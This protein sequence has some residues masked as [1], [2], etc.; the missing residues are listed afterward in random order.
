[1][2]YVNIEKK[3]YSW[4]FPLAGDKWMSCGSA[5][6]GHYTRRTS[7]HCSWAIGID[8]GGCSIVKVPEPVAE[9][10]RGKRIAVA[11]VSRNEGQAANAVYRK[12]R[13]S[14]YEALPV[15]PNT[16]HVEGVKCFPNL[17]SIPGVIDGVVV[18]THPD[19]SVELVRQCSG[20]EV[21][22]VWF[23]RSFGQGSVSDAA[24]HECEAR[25]IQCIVG[26]CPLMYSAPVD[27]GHRCM[28][29]WLGRQ[30]VFS[31]VRNQLTMSDRLRGHC[32]YQAA[33]L[34]SIIRIA[35]LIRAQLESTPW[36]H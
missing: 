18:A 34:A 15:N 32:V 2:R 20:R 1:L 28:R 26:G 27:L 36:T 25:G 7:V 16:S 31:A 10:L 4:I 19:V 13:D 3:N 6:A 23:H 33:E 35:I 5:V 30:G 24:I 17:A 8:A 21:S 11:G 12:L 9:F 22:R 29:W 14:A